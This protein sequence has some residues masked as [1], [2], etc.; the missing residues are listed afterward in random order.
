VVLSG[1]DKTGVYWA[2]QTILQLLEKKGDKVILHVCDINDWPTYLY[3]SLAVS[4]DREANIKALRYKINVLFNPWWSLPKNWRE[5]DER[6]IKTLQE[7]TEF[8]AKRG[9]TLTQ[10]ICPYN[11]N[12]KG[13]K[14][15][16]IQIS[17]SADIDKLFQIYK[18]S[19]SKGSRIINL[20]F[21][22]PS[23]E[24]KSFHPE[25]IKFFNGD[26]PKGHAYLVSELY[27]R[28][29]KEYPDAILTVVP[30]NYE[31]PI[32]IK[33]HYN[34]MKVP[35]KDVV[36]MWT[37][38]A[39]VTLSYNEEQIR[40]FKNDIEGREFIVF[41]NTPGQMYGYGKR[42]QMFDNY[43]SGY[44][45][46]W[47]Y[48]YGIHG[49][50]RMANPPTPCISDI[51]GMIMAEYMW[52]ADRYNAE[53]TVKKVL[54]KV[55]GKSS[56]EPL[57]SF[58]EYYLKIATKYPVWK[59][60]EELSIKEKTIYRISEEKYYNYIKPN[61]DKL[62]ENLEKIKMLT[63]NQELIKDL[64]TRYNWVVKDIEI[65]RE[66]SK[67]KKLFKPGEEILLLPEDFLGGTGYEIYSY[68]CEP[69]N[70]VWIYGQKTPLHTLEAEFE[71][72]YLPQNDGI[73]II[74]GQDD[75]KEGKTKIEI[76]LNGHVV[77]C[78]P[79]EFKEKGWST[80]SF[81]IKKSFWNLG[82]NILKIRN[83]EESDSFNSKWFML[84]YV[85]ITFF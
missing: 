73:L 50:H 85:K 25:D 75:E 78:G 7:E 27:K 53:I 6:Y 52:N 43:A 46:L 22:D 29:K 5:P 68:L 84:T 42:I 10:Q 76:S 71:L 32:D 24:V 38:S 41:D 66:N 61:V 70:A 72:A 44:N 36:I 58:K 23:R 77:F 74:E 28:M 80:C 82:K 67:V 48:C 45:N 47:K 51:Q 18:L 35:K 31:S 62:K 3:R 30:R 14:I 55:A 17:N 39:G 49:M 9:V 37:G 56:V 16:Q 33:G 81:T 63:L 54:A 79:N 69:K 26:I 60:P 12:Y 40:H 19:L 83:L 4:S 57:L 15:D 64:E 1:T 11:V 13:E 8:C 20:S 65:L 21:D 34:E 2:V 59:K